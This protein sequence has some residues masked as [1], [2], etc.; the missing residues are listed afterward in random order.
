MKMDYYR[1]AFRDITDGSRQPLRQVH[2][3]LILGLR[4]PAAPSI[5]E[6]LTLPD[7]GNPADRIGEDLR[8]PSRGSFP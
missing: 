1:V 5:L 2:G 8:N 7:L 4:Q 6:E 3:L